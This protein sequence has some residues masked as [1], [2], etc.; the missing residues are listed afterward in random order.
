MQC[1]LNAQHAQIEILAASVRTPVEVEQVAEMGISAVTLSL[2]VLQQ[3]PEPPR[4]M[5][6]FAVFNEAIRSLR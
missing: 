4:T 2:A 5:A 3:L 1:S 6:A